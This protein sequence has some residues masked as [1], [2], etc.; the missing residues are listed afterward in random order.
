VTEILDSSNSDLSSQTDRL[1][2]LDQDEG[3]GECVGGH[4]E[5]RASPVFRGVFSRTQPRTLTRLKQAR[6]PKEE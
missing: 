5:I 6:K 4:F 1:I 2:A 3:K